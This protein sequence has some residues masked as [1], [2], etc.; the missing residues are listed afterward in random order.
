MSHRS[1]AH[2]HHKLHWS[3]V[4]GGVALQDIASLSGKLNMIFS[5]KSV[6][7]D[8]IVH[9]FIS[10]YSEFQIVIKIIYTNKGTVSVC[11]R[12]VRSLWREG[13]RVEEGCEAARII[14]NQFYSSL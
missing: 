7:S 2:S 13:R 8:T 5:H 1:P 11:V 9:S 3:V 14:R 4:P 12:R 10:S 6:S